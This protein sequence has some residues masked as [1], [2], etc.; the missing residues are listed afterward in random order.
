MTDVRVRFA[1]S[2]TG[3]LHVGSARTALYNFL[4]ARHNRGTMVLRIEDTDLKRSTGDTSIINDLAWL[5]LRADEGQTWVVRS[6]TGRASA[7]STLASA[8]R[9]ARGRLEP[10]PVSALKICWDQKKKRNVPAG[11]CCPVRLARAARSP[12]AKWSS[13]VGWEERPSAWKCPKGDVVG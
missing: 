6:A 13:A 8:A 1:P 7:P 4:Y 3:S 9:T 10:I 12:R 5:G 2:P 11:R